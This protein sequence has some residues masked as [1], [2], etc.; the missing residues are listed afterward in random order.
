[1]KRG[2]SPF[3]F[4]PGTLAGAE[5][6]KGAMGPATAQRLQSYMRVSGTQLLLFVLSSIQGDIIIHLPLDNDAWSVTCAMAV[7]DEQIFTNRG[8]TT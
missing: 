8:L 5:L 3:G 4:R 6:R 2:A 7:L 1:M